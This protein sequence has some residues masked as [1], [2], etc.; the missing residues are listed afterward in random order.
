MGATVTAA[1]LTCVRFPGLR[2][3]HRASRQRRAYENKPELLKSMFVVCIVCSLA[4]QPQAQEGVQQ[5]CSRPRHEDA[6]CSII[7]VVKVGTSLST[8]LW[9]VIT[10]ECRGALRKLRQSLHAGREACQPLRSGRHRLRSNRSRPAV[11]W[12]R[13]CPHGIFGSVWTRHFCH[14]RGV[15]EPRCWHLVG[16]C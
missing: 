3:T 6:H 10:M 4:Q 9:S 1:T 12:G 14:N 8:S 15:G 11:S 16:H 13:F 5:K 7:A 2:K